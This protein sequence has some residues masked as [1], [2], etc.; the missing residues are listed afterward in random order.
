MRNERKTRTCARLILVML[1]FV[2]AAASGSV[3]ARDQGPGTRTLRLATDPAARSGQTRDDLDQILKEISTYNSGVDSAAFW[4]LRD[5]VQARK[6]DPAGRAECEKKLLAFLKTPAT[7]VARMAACRYLRAIAA[8]GAVPALAAMLADDRSADIAINALQ[9][10]PGPAADKA[11]LQ[12]LSLP[13]TTGSVKIAIVAALGERRTRDAVPALVPLLKQPDLARAAAFSLG[14]IG[15]EAADQALR[16]CFSGAP[17]E[18]KPVVAGAM[19]QLAEQSLAAKN[20]R[21]ALAL[22]EAV[23]ADPSLPV[24][25]RKAAAIGTIAAGGAS[26][27]QKLLGYL[28]GSDVAMQE[29]AIGK[30]S[31]VVKPPRI[32]Q[33]CA[34]LPRLPAA[35]Q[36]K[37]LAVLAGYP[38]Q[39]VL[40]AV[41]DAAR[42]NSVA[43]RIAAMKTLESVGDATVVPSLCDAAAKA[44][45]P[46]QT[47]A[48]TAL[49][50]LHGRPVDDAIVALMAK[51]PSEDV[52]AEL[53][54]AVADRRIFSAKS[55]VAA[56]FTAASPR[57]RQ[58]A[59]KSMRAIGTPSDMPAVLDVLVRSQDDDERA[60]AEQTTVALAQ[61]IASADNR[62]GAV[63]ARLGSEKDPQARVRLIGV[64]ARIGDNSSLPLLRNV[65]V[66]GDTDEFDAAVRAL[67]AWPTSAARDDVLL[68]ARDSRNETHRLL[69]IRGFVRII[70][71]DRY[72]LPEAAVAD[73]KQA[74]GF[75]W[76]PEEQ[77]LVLGALPQFACTDALE[78]ANGFLREPAVK[79]EAQAAIDKIKERMKTRRTGT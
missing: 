53:L 77:K 69:A 76:R 48:R 46:E 16:A 9:L 54:L 52:Q 61:K 60:E 49:G 37:L 1:L 27:E 38:A 43:V 51:P 5:Y 73:L 22:Y 31:E 65:L 67:T 19:M 4:K 35:S 34:L 32:G 24:P 13:K 66:S 23:F 39:A 68:L 40:P 56:S 12:G 63:K 71:L 21:A 2:I 7:P 15:G 3:L 58:Q 20:D 45:G 10:I 29:A 33:V 74:A 26:A 30:V 36:I 25:V 70:G 79:A 57:V 62:A 75:S 72:R 14:R 64:L 17:A 42:G 18:L 78:F 44:T 47:A 41:L 8:D 50:M 59:L 11:L 28:S 6:D 55:L